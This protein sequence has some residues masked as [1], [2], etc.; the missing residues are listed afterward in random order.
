MSSFFP[1]IYYIDFLIERG[2]AYGLE[3]TVQYQ[4]KRFFAWMAYSL[5]KT[6][7]FDGLQYYAP[8]YDRRHDLNL[9]SSYTLGKDLAFKLQG[10]WHYGSGFPFTPTGGFYEKL[11]LESLHG[12]DILWENGLLGISFGDYNSA[13]LPDFHRLDLSLKYTY[14]F[15]ASQSIEATLSCS[16]VYNRN[17]LFYYD[18]LTY[19]RK[20]Q[21]PIL[22]SGGIIWRF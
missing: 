9:L 7:R 12:E 1:E 16:N 17:N 13:R 10:R 15:G 2:S 11:Q 21:L 3:G 20:D 4:K 22:I 8:H 5:A 14:S 19:D 6:Q 18:R